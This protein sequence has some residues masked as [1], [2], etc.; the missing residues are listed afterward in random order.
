MYTFGLGASALTLEGKQYIVFGEL[1]LGYQIQ[2]EDRAPFFPLNPDGRFYDD[3]DEAGF[4]GKV[5]L[6]GVRRL[7]DHWQIGGSIEA[8]VS[9]EYD[10][11]AARLFL[12]WNFK[13]RPAV[14]SSDIDFTE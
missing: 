8:Q 5:L 12:R 4:G 7:D 10:N 9:P 2:E 11:Y 3:N 13:G 6:R 1:Q 14:V